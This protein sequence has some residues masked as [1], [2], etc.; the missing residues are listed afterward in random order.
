MAR[1]KRNRVLHQSVDRRLG[2]RLPEQRAD[3][4][5]KSN[6]FFRLARSGCG[7]HLLGRPDARQAHLG[8]PHWQYAFTDAGPP[9][10]T[11]SVVGVDDVG[12][13]GCGG[14]PD[15]TEDGTSPEPSS[16]C[17][18]VGKLHA[19]TSSLVPWF[20]ASECRFLR[21]VLGVPSRRSISG[22][23]DTPGHKR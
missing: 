22:Q 21:G 20:A 8:V 2:P 14:H 23:G 9:P 17:Q 6:Q 10:A 16:Q 18:R 1:D 4:G 11:R 19:C 5:P 3:A 12:G 7:A 13:L 15:E